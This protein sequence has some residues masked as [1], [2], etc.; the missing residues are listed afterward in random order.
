MP[1]PFFDYFL[2]LK[3][4]EFLENV[5]PDKSV[6]PTISPETLRSL[7]LTDEAT[8][9]DIDEAQKLKDS[10]LQMIDFSKPINDTVSVP[11]MGET[12]PVNQPVTRLND[13]PDPEI[14]G[15]EDLKPP[16]FSKGIIPDKWLTEEKRRPEL[17][18]SLDEENDPK[19]DIIDK[20]NRTPASDTMNWLNKVSKGFLTTTLQTL[21]S[22]ITLADGVMKLGMSA[23][24]EEYNMGENSEDISNALGFP[25]ARQWVDETLPTI[26]TDSF[27]GNTVPYGISSV[28]FFLTGGLMSSGMKLGTTGSKVLISLLGAGSQSQSMYEQA[29]EGGAT[30][31]E[32]LTNLF[33]GAGIGASES[34]LGLGRALTQLGKNIGKPVMRAIAEGGVEEFF[35]ETVQTGLENFTVQQTYDFSRS[36]EDGVVDAGLFAL[37]S[38]GLVSG[39]VAHANK[40]MN[41]PN[42][43][44]EDKVKLSQA[45]ENFKIFERKLKEQSMVDIK[46][47]YQ[48][49][50][51]NQQEQMSILAGRLTPTFVNSTRG[52]RVVKNIVRAHNTEGGSSFTAKG[53]VTK[54]YSVATEQGT[55]KVIKGKKITE[56]DILDFIEEKKDLLKNPNNFV[57]TWYNPDTGNTE[58]DVSTAV[59]TEEEAMQMANANSQLGIWDFKNKQFVE[60][61]PMDMYKMKQEQEKIPVE[62]SI[63]LFHFTDQDKRMMISDPNKF[64]KNSFTGNDKKASKVPRTFFFSNPKAVQNEGQRFAGKNLYRSTVDMRR[65]YNLTENRQGYGVNDYGNIDIDE[66]LK[67]AK[68]DGWDGVRYEISGNVYWNMFKPQYMEKV[69]PTPTMGEIVS[70]KFDKMIK[71]AQK[72]LNSGYYGNVFGKQ[73]NNAGNIAGMGVQLIADL[74]LVIGKKFAD[75]TMK[76]GTPRSFMNQLIEQYGETIPEVRRVAREVYE[77]AKMVKSKMEESPLTEEQITEL[78]NVIKERTA[79]GNYGSYIPTNKGIIVLSGDILAFDAEGKPKQLGVGFAKAHALTVAKEN[80]KVKMVKVAFR[81]NDTGKILQGESTMHFQLAEELDGKGMNDIYDKMEAGLIEDGFIGNDGKFYTRSE[82][83]QLTGRQGESFEQK[84]AVPIPIM[85]ELTQ[86]QKDQIKKDRIE[87]EKQKIKKPSYP[88]WA[89]DLGVAKQLSESAT[90]HGNDTMVFVA[91]P[92]AW[93]SVVPNRDFHSNVRRDI[94]ALVGEENVPALPKPEQWKSLSVREN[95]IAEIKDIINNKIKKGSDKATRDAW[96]LDNIAYKWGIENGINLTGKILGVAKFK[97]V[98]YNM[99][100]EGGKDYRIAPH[101]SYPA[102]IEG[103]NY[104]EFDEPISFSKFQDDTKGTDVGV[105][106]A[107]KEMHGEEREARR[108]SNMFR[109]MQQHALS[110]PAG[111]PLIDAVID[112]S[113]GDYSKINKWLQDNPDFRGEIYDPV[114]HNEW[115]N[116][117]KRLAEVEKLRQEAN[118]SME[119]VYRPETV[120]NPKRDSQGRLPS[121]PDYEGG[122]T[123]NAFFGQNEWNAMLAFG[124]AVARGAKSFTEFARKMISQFGEIIKPALRSIFKAVNQ[125]PNVFKKAGKTEVTY[126]TQSNKQTEPTTVNQEQS[127]KN[128]LMGRTPSITKGYNMEREHPL[129][130][131]ILDRML[132]A[133]RKEFDERRRGTI[134]NEQLKEEAKRRAEHLTDEDIFN[135]KQG[136]ILNAETTLAYRIYTLNKLLQNMDEFTKLKKESD[137]LDIKNVAT[138][139]ANAYRMYQIVRAV[140]TEAGRVVQSFNIPMDDEFLSAVLMGMEAMKQFDPD[141]KYGTGQVQEIIKEVAGTKTDTVEKKKTAW[142]IIR[143]VFFNWILQNPLTDMANVGGNFTNLSFHI[144][145]N[146]GNL[147]GIKTL[148]KGIKNGFREGIRSAQKVIHGEEQAI[149]K[150]SEWIENVDTPAT[151]KRS[152][153]NYL[154][155]LVPTTRLGLED[156]FFRSLGRNIELSRMAYKVSKQTNVSPDDIASAVANIINDPDAGKFSRKEYQDMAKY[157]QEIEDEL[158]FQ[159]ELGR[160][161]KGMSMVSK[162]AYPIMPFVKTPLNILKFGV[163]A[164]PFG[165]LK[166]FKSGLS[167]EE[168]NQ[169]TRRALAGSVVL[170]GL[171]GLIA[172]GLVEITGGGSD[173]DYERDLMAKLGYKPYHIYIKT[174]MGTFGGSYMNLNPMN[175]AL[176]V[177]GDMYDKYRFNKNN[178]KP[179]E[180]LAWYDRVAQDLSTALIAVG[181]SV[182]DQ[183]Y[184][185]GV[186]DLMDAL[187]GRNPDWLLRT[188]TGYARMGGIQGIQQVTGTLDRGVYDTRGRMMEQIQKNSPLMSNEG[189]IPK[190]ST[191]G[192]HEQSQ[193]ERFALPLT[194]PKENTA[195]NWLKDNDLRVKQPSKNTKLGNTVIDREHYAI[196]TKRVGEV[197]DKV[198]QKLWEQQTDPELPEEKKLTLEKLQKVLDKAYDK[199][200]DDTK[201]KI[202]ESIIEQYQTQKGNK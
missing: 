80:E 156:A 39:M 195:Y 130:N 180:D 3:E 105:F 137:P 2:G 125:M 11:Q 71:D 163:G 42:I 47:S 119:A 40:Q 92:N 170:S 146:I 28:A 69:D 120:L 108:R 144:I 95:Y 68:K 191:F 165:A 83:R 29:I 74:G 141:G 89:T 49:G 85:G 148:T 44:E 150:F 133:G 176:T 201:E 113:N 23:I 123:L 159:K 198:V 115:L 77:Y 1:L 136:D 178:S 185:S 4:P 126:A 138:G 98:N 96:K 193:Y 200:V 112:M 32:A 21:Q 17:V 114:K 177:M 158:V 36:L 121:H 45:I 151:K 73:A 43:S 149:S 58:L 194:S 142:D 38:G 188:L 86:E 187:A 60:T 91:Y 97:Q 54:G 99:T 181:S 20:T 135:V 131:S 110:A 67:Q 117:P 160:F 118:K 9:A 46:Q 182:T 124:K 51:L 64:G 61:V 132:E 129:L 186:R 48:I 167:Q 102:E 57:G 22:P 88:I 139:V 41:D 199:A 50:N 106:G 196:L 34:V 15:I 82:T 31:E 183:S 153:K 16:D 190:Y 134:G 33:A 168:R 90:L 66:A 111:T 143:F 56:K 192:E 197:M 35:Q 189:L 184:L 19:A 8:Q 100:K 6:A 145:A 18:L 55:A 7:G 107:V 140:G 116:N 5:D 79:S 76:I 10:G 13:I 162:V 164:T 171:S 72:R 154:R 87:K 37:M 14:R 127:K 63:Q 70:G 104:Q 26:D 152:W 81:D 25:E 155:L 169:I 62:H 174:P 93:D 172:Q 59:A 101:P 147:G 12:V 128:Q 166:L 65:V 75:K 179:E 52:Q 175:T 109:W 94:V 161:G 53:R 78:N 173:D 27:W 157:I 103:Y 24:G 122:I 30:E 84:V 202:I